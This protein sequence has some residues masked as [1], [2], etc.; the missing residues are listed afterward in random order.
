MEYIEIVEC[1]SGMTVAT[2]TSGP[3]DA[4]YWYNDGTGLKR[5]VSVYHQGRTYDAVK[6]V[7][8]SRRK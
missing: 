7:D 8:K 2:L 6:K 4:T 1:A 5:L 3:N